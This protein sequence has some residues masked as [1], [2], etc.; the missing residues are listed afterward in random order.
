LAWNEVGKVE[1]DQVRMDSVE[2]RLDV[3]PWAK[4]APV[5]LGP[6]VAKV[7]RS[8]AEEGIELETFDRFR[9]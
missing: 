7:E 1:P 2:G 3:D 4:A 5:D 8:L 6:V 9:S